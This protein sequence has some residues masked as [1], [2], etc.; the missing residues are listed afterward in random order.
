MLNYDQTQDYEGNKVRSVAGHEM[1]HV[2]GLAH[3]SGCILMR[4][5]TSWRYDVCGVYTPQGDDINGFGA[6][7]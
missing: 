2:F 1:G 3:D 4:S 6:L 5:T 7:Y